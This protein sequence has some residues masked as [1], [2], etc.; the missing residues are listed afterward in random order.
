[1]P[2]PL[3]VAASRGVEYACLGLLLLWLGG[4]L[5]SNAAHHL[6]AGLLVGLAFGGVLLMLAAAAGTEALS[7]ASLS[8]WVVNELL[9]PAGCA[10][11]IFSTTRPRPAPAPSPEKGRAAPAVSRRK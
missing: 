2:P 5:W 8:A 6:G 11:I 9:F 7:A 4:K 3:L 1:M 10:L